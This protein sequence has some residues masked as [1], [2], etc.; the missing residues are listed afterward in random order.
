M[1][2]CVE[3]R[4]YFLEDGGVVAI[5]GWFDTS[6]GSFVDDVTCRSEDVLSEVRTVREYHLCEC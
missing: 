3:E 2:G 1:V 5:F 6:D 4:G